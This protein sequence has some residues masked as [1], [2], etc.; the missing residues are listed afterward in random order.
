M[1]HTQE[2][3]LIKYNQLIKA[4][5]DKIALLKTKIDRFSI[6]R[7]ILLIIEI[8]LFISLV[9]SETDQAIIT[10][11]VLMIIPIAIFI[12]VV[13][14][15]N[16]LSKAENYFKNLLWIYENE[17]NVINAQQNGYD[18]GVFFEDESHP[19]LSDL[20]IFG[21]ASLYAL[22]NRC[23]TKNGIDLLANQFNY[24][25][26]KEKIEQ[27][28]QT[29][30]EI[31]NSIDD[32]F[33]FRAILKGNDANAIEQLK[34]KLNHKL[35]NQLKFIH[36]P[37]LKLYI[38]VLPFV[39]PILIFAGVIIGG[40]I[41]GILSLIILLH[42]GLTFFN[43]KKINE[44]YY[45]FGGS[46][47]LL[48]DS[49]DAIKWTEERSWHSKYIQSLFLADEKVSNEIKKLS[50]I[51]QAFDARLNLLV[52][53]FL[54]F[55]LLWDLRCCAKLDEWHQKSSVNVENGLN[56][57]SCFEEIISIATL[58]YN[59]PNWVFPELENNFALQAD[60]L[61]HPLIAAKKCVA[62][63][64]ALTTKPTV[65]IVTGSNMAG[66]S[67]FL[68]TLGI[69]MVL[70]Y[71]GAPVC[72]KSMKLS[73]FNILT[74][75]R[76]KDSLNES[77]STFK[78]ELNRLKMILQ[79]V[80]EHENS[81]VLIDEM[82]RG[83]NSR[84]KFL[85]SKVFIEKLIAV[86][87]PTLFATHDLQLSELQVLYPEAVRNYHFDIQ[88]INGEMEFDYKIKNGPC[89]KFNAAILLKQIG[90]T[91]DN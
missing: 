8:F 54:N 75:M 74:Y 88:I 10:G 87:T 23:S 73:I 69:N 52:G 32:T 30:K 68:R 67:T 65:D 39:M 55:T 46:A 28:Q 49:A 71:A 41:W 11:V 22:T 38:K 19:Y 63:N 36:Q 48:A 13:K 2:Q 4:T 82:L 84:D 56:R 62:N 83:T 24:P 86:K 57:L 1:Q 3:V 72:A 15:Q 27:R 79:K 89:D 37:I 78:A 44:V 70:A 21:K 33:N 50:K 42:A 26:S 34:T 91:I 12:I 61:G 45:G 51:I 17:V 6:I 14:K 9:R 29:I 80:E 85:G 66:K 31:I 81:L 35:A 43:M 90:L 64:F 18:N 77:T 25:S 5:A 47:L 76:I 20:D 7:V 16:R 59:N 53:S 60:E 40:K 58:S